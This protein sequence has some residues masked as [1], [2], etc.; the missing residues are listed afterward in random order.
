MTLKYLILGIIQGLTEPIPVSSS[1]HLRVFRE[2]FNGNIF[3][4]LNFEIVVNFAS[5]LAILFIFRKDIKRLLIGFFNYIFK[6]EKKYYDD[7]KYC[8]YIVIAS[9]PVGITGLLLKDTID[10]KLGNLTIL[11]LAFLLTSICLFVVSKYKGHKEDKDITYMDATLIGLLQGITIMP[12]ISRSGTVLV[13]C[14]LRDFKRDVALRFTFIL[15]FPVSLASFALGVLDIIKDSQLSTIF[16]PYTIGF[17]GS[18]ITTYFAYNWMSKM[19]KNGKLWKFAIYC[20]LLSL[21]VL[22]IL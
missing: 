4:D 18:L 16:L 6:K 11:G 1:G 12:G 21:F 15:Y 7:F 8:I 13:G 19:V 17:V 14:L 10:S 9:I 3:N 5:F 20:F 2:L 22:F